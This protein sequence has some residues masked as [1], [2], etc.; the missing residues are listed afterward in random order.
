[1][2]EKEDENLAASKKYHVFRAPATRRQLQARR[3]IGAVALEAA[4]PLAGI[5]NPAPWRRKKGVAAWLRG[6][7]GILVPALAEA[8]SPWS[9]DHGDTRSRTL[10]YP[11]ADGSSIPTLASVALEEAWFDVCYLSALNERARELLSNADTRLAV[12]GR[13]AL[14]WLADIDASPSAPATVR[15]DAIAW[16][17]RLRA[18]LTPEVLAKPL[19]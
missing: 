15:L 2:G 13:R 7:G 19:S 10:L 16:L 4:P 6:Y 1:M 3:A 8:A 12:E 14:A 17:E 9:D 11:A 18:I 5:E